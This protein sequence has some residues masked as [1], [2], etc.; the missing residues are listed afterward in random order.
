MSGKNRSGCTVLEEEV[1]LEVVDPGYARKILAEL[2]FK[3]VKVC[4]EVDTYFAH[5]CRDF[6]STD[7]ALRLRKRICN[8]EE[9]FVLTYKGPRLG[10]SKE[11]KIREE[12]EVR[13]TRDVLEALSQILTKL[14]FISILSF[15]KTREIYEASD[16]L[17]YLDYI[18][19]LG[20]FL[21]FEARTEIGKQLIRGILSSSH[22]N[23]RI[24]EETYLE[25]CL[26]TK[27][28]QVNTEI[29]GRA[30]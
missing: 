21:E 6:A 23:A 8:D 5:P 17:A 9:S 24:V 25:M 3:F 26:R 18:H 1:K 11:I 16:V 29:N 30:F 14:G 13:L 27:K 22:G 15:S 20:Y 28:C 7:E 4:T 10:V 12:I 2:G 19:G